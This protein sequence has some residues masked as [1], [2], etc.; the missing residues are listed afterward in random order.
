MPFYDAD[1]R[2]VHHQWA[3]F[4]AG[5]SCHIK[6]TWVPAYRR[7]QRLQPQTQSQ[8][9]TQ[10]Q[11]PLQ[12]PVHHHYSTN[13]KRLREGLGIITP[14]HFPAELNST[15]VF[16]CVRVSSSV[17]DGKDQYAYQ[18]TVSIG[19]HVFK[20]ILYDQGPEDEQ[21]IISTVHPRHHHHHHHHQRQEF[22]LPSSSSC[23]LMTTTSPFTA[24]MSG[25]E[26][27]PPR[28]KP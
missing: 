1:T 11:Q 19:G 18:T 25:T 12:R 21:R 2:Q 8:T 5:A 7:R 4:V 6:S 13:P 15:A 22:L 23:P 9:Q 26:F 14:T 17:D 16:R 20:G 3:S 24:F 27:S 28:Q 10:T